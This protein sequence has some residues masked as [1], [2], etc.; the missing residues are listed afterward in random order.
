MSLSKEQTELQMLEAKLKESEAAIK[1]GEER[2][3]IQHQHE[4]Q[5]ADFDV[6]MKQLHQ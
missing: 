2:L 4:Q 3:R 6:K 5:C 1:T